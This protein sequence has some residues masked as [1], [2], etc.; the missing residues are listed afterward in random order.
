MIQLHS[1]YRRIQL[2][3]YLLVFIVHIKTQLAQQ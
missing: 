3:Q 2:K 1:N